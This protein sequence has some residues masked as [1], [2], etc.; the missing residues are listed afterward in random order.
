MTKFPCEIMVWVS[1]PD[2]Q[3]VGTWATT[4]YPDDAR[5][6]VAKEI[7]DAVL[8]AAQLGLSMARANDLTNTADAI[9]EALDGSALVICSE[10]LTQ[11]AEGGK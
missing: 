5:A 9:Q 4:R 10:A 3:H 1:N 8:A 2:L 11:N 6:Y 7:F